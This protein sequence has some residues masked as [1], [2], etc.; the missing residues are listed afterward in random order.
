MES[1]DL[2][3]GVAILAMLIAHGA[4]FLWPTGMSRP[5]EML[6]GGI[7]A[8][9]SPLFGLVM[10]AAAAIVWSRPLTLERWP[11]RTLADIG[12]GVL[13]FGLGVLLVD[14]DTWV[15]IVLHVLGVLMVLGLPVAALAGAAL[16]GG[17]SSGLWRAAT[18]TSTVAA[19]VAAPWLTGTLAPA[20]ERIANGRAGDWSELWVA[21]TAGSSYRAVS[22]LP[23]FTLGAALTASGLVR[24]PRRLA[25][26]AG[27]SAGLLA[28]LRLAGVLR[29]GELSGDVMDQWWDLTLVSVAV[30]VIAGVLALGPRVP[31]ALRQPLADLGTIALSVYALQLLVLKPL[32]GLDLWQTSARWGWMCLLALVLV[33]SVA[34]VT[35]RRVLG[36]GPLELVVAL[37]T[38]KVRA[39]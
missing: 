22:L 17:R 6:L 5:V 28:A 11:R 7:N 8:L 12:R 31:A 30:A 4:P 32:M 19:F 26:L 20:G 39:S 18:W 10:G 14:V 38:G 23:F 3:R 13:V 25:L 29:P 37:V 34:M 2:L 36:P 24:Q 21:L 16:R 35:W 9:A 15:A 1:V 33:P 27:V